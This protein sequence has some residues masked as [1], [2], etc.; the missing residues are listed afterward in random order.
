MFDVYGG[1]SGVETSPDLMQSWDWAPVCSTWIG[2]MQVPRG[3]SLR[4]PI[5]DLILVFLPFITSDEDDLYTSELN[6][7]G[8]LTIIVSF[9]VYFRFARLVL[10]AFILFNTENCRLSLNLIS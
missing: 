2:R 9:A 7:H 3:S 6:R 10:C 1:P 5:F 4:V 8:L